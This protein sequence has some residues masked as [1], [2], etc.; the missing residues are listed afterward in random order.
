MAVRC[1]TEAFSTT[2]AVHIEDCEGWWLSSCHGSVAEPWH[3]KPEMS[4]VQLLA[5][6][7]LFIFVYFHLITYIYRLT[8]VVQQKV[9][10]LKRGESTSESTWDELVTEIWEENGLK[11]LRDA[12]TPF[13]HEEVFTYDPRKGTYAFQEGY[14]VTEEEDAFVFI[15]Q[16]DH[17]ELANQLMQVQPAKEEP[18]PP[19]PSSTEETSQPCK[20]MHRVKK[21]ISKNQVRGTYT[22]IM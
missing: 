4:W 13:Q 10:A 21:S 18:K 9:S 16:R 14:E 22:P 20:Q 15:D 11:H 6:D 3:L 12:A 1:V 19:V 7:G 17:D 2:C 5:T 8:S